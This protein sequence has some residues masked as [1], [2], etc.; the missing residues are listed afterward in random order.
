[1][2]PDVPSPGPELAAWLEEN[3][4]T[5]IRRWLEL[6]VE[7]SSLEELTTRPLAERI[8]ELDLLLEAARSE[9]AGDTGPDLRDA[10]AAA[11]QEGR[12][13]GLALIAPPAGGPEP[14]EWAGAARET[15][16]REERVIPAPGG[17]VGVLI[18]AAGGGAARV[19]ADRIRAGAWQL[20][21]G[22]S[23]LPDAGLAVHPGDG[24][25]AEE[26][27]AAARDRLPGAAHA[28]ESDAVPAH[29]DEPPD[30]RDEVRVSRSESGGALR[31]ELDR[32]SREDR[33]EE[34][35]D[36]WREL[37]ERSREPADD[38]PPADVTPLYPPPLD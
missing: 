16:R 22:S 19:E 21:G 17:L 7:R 30:F 24:S 18:P 9:G 33:Q 37:A 6:V 11:L 13:F 5:L 3:R 10:L 20:L 25:T 1:M 36:L 15:A 35:R 8:R 27:V 32:W 26:L 31:Q 12:P 29:G 14:A 23:P 4:E 38:G 34:R 28:A 2:S